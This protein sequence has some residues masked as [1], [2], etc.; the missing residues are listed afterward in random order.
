MNKSIIVCALTALSLSSC[1]DFLDVQPEGDATITNYFTN[2]QQAIDAVD[3]IYAPIAQE[4]LFGREIYWEQGAACDIVWAKT[5]SY[6]TLAT[7]KYTGDE[8][9]LRDAFKNL[10]TIM[11]RANYVIDGLIDKSNRTDI[12]ERSL[13]EAYF[14]RAFAHFWIAHRYGTDKLGVPFVR[15]EEFEGSYDNSIPPQAETVMDNYRM[16]CED[17]DAAMS[18]LPRFETYGPDDQGRPHKAAALGL[19]VRTNAYWATWEPSKW[20]DVIAGVDQLE[21]EFGRGLADSF[22][23][24]FTPEFDKWWNREYIYTFV[25]N[26]GSEGGGVELP[27]VMLEDKGWGLYNGWGQ[28]K[29]SND[30]YEEMLSDG[31]DNERLKYSILSYGDKFEYFGEERTFYSTTNLN[32]GF[33]VYKFQH[34]FADADC[35]AKGYVNPNGNWPTVRI[36][37][38]MIR[39]AEMLLLRAEANIMQGNGAAA[40]EDINKI[41]RRS[42]LK[43]ITGPATGADLYHERRCEL[44]FEYTN[45]LFDLKRWHRCS[46]TDLQSLAAAELNKRPTVRFYE[47]RG[48]PASSFTVGL[49]EDY[50]DKLPYQDYMM[51]FPYPSEQVAN[52]NG[53]LKNIPEWN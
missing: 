47:D 20:S 40:T 22:E 9:P 53:Q 41:R 51:T 44:A 1:S 26:G 31:E 15:W 50:T 43:E 14:M 10:Y 49:Y 27:G 39:M 3:A 35:Q 37:F 8:S 25:S 24:N 2:D 29:P 13:G 16:I 7:F 48:D 23:D 34:A 21:S 52:S 12:E 33:Q 30:L 19:K 36:N 5:R 17:L 42:H 32:V 6:P 28:I 4:S 46:N 38:P 45:H 11:S 18:H